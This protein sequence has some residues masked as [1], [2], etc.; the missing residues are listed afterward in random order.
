MTRWVEVE[1]VGDSDFIPGDRVEIRRFR[2]V[3]REL[4]REKKNPAEGKPVLLG[5]KQAPL[6]GGIG[7]VPLGSDSWLAP[8][9][10]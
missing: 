3:N 1:E 5:I 2:S 7:R 8:A 10:L 9:F 4:I 6:A